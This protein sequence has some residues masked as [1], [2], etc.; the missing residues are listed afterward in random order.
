MSPGGLFTAQMGHVSL[1]WSHRAAP[2]SPKTSQG[3]WRQQLWKSRE[4]PLGASQPLSCSSL[5][6]Q[7]ITLM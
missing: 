6:H 1:V 4:R 2:Q 3:C 7:L 5:R